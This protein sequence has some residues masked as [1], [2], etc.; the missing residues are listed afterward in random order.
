MA[1]VLG[2]IGNLSVGEFLFIAI[3]A[4]LVFGRNLPQVLGQLYGQLVKMRRSFDQL[5]RD[6]GIDH[7]L[8]RMRTT[9]EDTAREAQF[10][11]PMRSSVM[12]TLAAPARHE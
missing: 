8:R 2:L 5:R 12:P 7:E 1:A 6:T 10:N 9:L 4:V 3:L 11:D